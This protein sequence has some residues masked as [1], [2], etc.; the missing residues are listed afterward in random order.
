MAH[1]QPQSFGHGGRPPGKIRLTG[2]RAFTPNTVRLTGR[3]LREIW[4]KLFRR[5]GARPSVLVVYA[6]SILS[7]DL[8]LLPMQHLA[9]EVGPTSR[10]VPRMAGGRNRVFRRR[11]PVGTGPVSIC[12]RRYPESVLRA[13]ARAA[14]RNDQSALPLRVDEPPHLRVPAQ[15]APARHP[16]GGP[17]PRLQP[18]ELR[19]A[20]VERSDPQGGQPLARRA[21]G[22]GAHDRRGVSS[23]FRRIQRR[24]HFRN[25]W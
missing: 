11:Q 10:R 14:V 9:A 22:A 3:Q 8:H 12:R 17:C 1:L 2:I 19:R 23:R 16:A 24:P 25:R 20:I 18:P 4:V 6:H 21:R 15:L 5:P 13:A 7:A